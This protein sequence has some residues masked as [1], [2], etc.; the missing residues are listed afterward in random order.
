MRVILN[1]SESL[2]IVPYTYKE[3]CTDFLHDCVPLGDLH[4]G[5]SL[6]SFSNLRGDAKCSAEGI[7]FP[8]G[9]QIFYNFHSKEAAELFVKGV[10]RSPYFGFGMRVKSVFIQQNPSFEFHADGV[11]FKTTSNVLVKS[12]KEDSKGYEFLFA[13][14]PKANVIMTRI[15]NNKAKLAG[16]EH[17]GRVFFDPTYKRT[18]LKAWNYKGIVNKTSACPIV[19][20]G[21]PEILEFA[22]N[23]GVGNS[24]GI[25]FGALL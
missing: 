18:K 2:E 25:G 19:V 3:R 6:F 14:D 11:V 22:W 21:H 5:P 20:Q 10:K 9:A 16:I 23:V 8:Y 15:L 1:L 24:T 12:K 7:N 4:G 17:I 13:G